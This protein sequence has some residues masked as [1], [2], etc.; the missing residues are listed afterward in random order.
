MHI[1]A[2]LGHDALRVNGEIGPHRSC[3]PTYCSIRVGTFHPREITPDRKSGNI[4][5]IQAVYIDPI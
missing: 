2:K 3:C 1:Y 4:C 5:D